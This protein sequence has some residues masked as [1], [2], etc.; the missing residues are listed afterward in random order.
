MTELK[1]LKDIV[2][3]LRQVKWKDAGEE[4]ES[5]VK[6]MLSYKQDIK[7]EAIKWYKDMEAE[8]PYGVHTQSVQIW[9]KV[10]FNLNE[11]NLK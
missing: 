5:R 3:N 9:I 8:Q 6:I 7:M 4:T 1:T 10:F 2:I 11:E